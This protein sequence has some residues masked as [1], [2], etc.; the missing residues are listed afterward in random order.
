M[1]L[2]T[3][4][5]VLKTYDYRETS[6]IAV[7]FTK[8]FGKVSGVMKGIRKDPRKFASSVDQ[9]S[10]NTIVYYQY[11][12]S[13]LHLISQ[14]DMHHFFQVIRADLRRSMAA[15]YILELVHKIMPAEQRNQK[16]YQLM[17]SFLKSLETTADVTQLVHMFQIKL[18][19]FSGFRPHLDSCVK[20]KKKMTSDALFSSQEGGLLCP[21]HHGER[22]L[23]RI[24]KG[25]V[26]TI[27]HVEQNLW[28]DCLK[29]RFTDSV[30]KE[31]KYLLNH[32]L[33]F[34]LGRNVRSAAY[35]HQ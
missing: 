24:S 22:S 18:L 27:L 31:L 35:V 30:R 13:D 3:E 29:L 6:R 19:L 32:F 33:I 23:P 26:A 15:S 12:N 16:I 25:T 5:I 17:I 2:K 11:R 20:C 21:D 9:C 7:F 10:V 14:C 8:D 28:Q 1:I 4:A 34:H